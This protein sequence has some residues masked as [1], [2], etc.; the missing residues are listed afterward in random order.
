MPISTCLS[1]SQAPLIWDQF[2]AEILTGIKRQSGSGG[3]QPL[4]QTTGG[5]QQLADMALCMFSR[6]K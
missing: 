5:D 3:S 4:F 6:M 1:R 2:L